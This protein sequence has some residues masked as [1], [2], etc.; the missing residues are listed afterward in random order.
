M[1]ANVGCD[2]T[3]YKVHRPWGDSVSFLCVSNAF[4]ALFHLR[5]AFTVLVRCFCITIV[6]SVVGLKLD[7]QSWRLAEGVTIEATRNPNTT[8][9]HSADRQM[10]S[11]NYYDVIFKDPKIPVESSGTELRV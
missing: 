2:A 3:C 9:C 6:R 4:P 5:M 1:V 10:W 7:V 8:Y 11:E